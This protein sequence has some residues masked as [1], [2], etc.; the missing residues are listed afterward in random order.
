M[1]FL[2][3]TSLSGKKKIAKLI[4]AHDKGESKNSAYKVL[5]Q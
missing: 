4:T 1:T 3:T 2:F 5:H